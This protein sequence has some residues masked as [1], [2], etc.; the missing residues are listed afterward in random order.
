MSIA[1]EELRKTVDGSFVGIRLNTTKV[2]PVHL[3]N[4][5]FRAILG[6]TA[7]TRLLHRFV[8][9]QEATGEIP[10][11]HDLDSVISDLLD[12]EAIEPGIDPEKIAAFRRQ[13]KQVVSADNGV[14]TGQMQSYSAGAAAFLSKD[15]VGQD[16][17]G[18]VASW[19][20]FIGSPLYKQIEQCLHDQTDIV[21][22]LCQPLLTNETEPF[23]IFANIEDL[24]FTESQL[25]V[26]N[27]NTQWAGLEKAAETLASNLQIHPDKLFRL[28]M[29]VLFSAFVVMRHVSSLESYYDKEKSNSPPPFLLEFGFNGNLKDASKQSYSR[30][31]Q[32]I[33]RF[34][35]FAFGEV[36]KKT[37]T[38]DQLMRCSPP[39]YKEGTKKKVDEQGDNVW[40]VK[41]ESAKTA[42]NKFLLFGEAIFDILAL[43]AEAD[44]IRY[45]RGLGRR[46]GL[47]HPPNGGT[48]PWF[49]PKH[50][51]VE[52]MIY[53]CIEPNESLELS[54]LCERMY[55]RFGILVG[56]G[57][58]DESVLESNGI[59][60]WD[61]DS[62]AENSTAFSSALVDHGFATQLADGVLKVSLE[63]MV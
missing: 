9:H 25:R 58:T 24:K 52:L 46:I 17:G 13:L 55:E 42:K 38:A 41:R 45:F 31:T 56:G 47:L 50:D 33:A 7:S 15:T 44:P 23:E 16:A 59:F 19:L 20:Q 6:K 1:I 22:Q 40:K 14:F 53:S 26:R 36:L 18:F 11:G 48:V 27:K 60:S 32:S 30:C 37:H 57:A 29:T 43:Q 39:R 28:R 2:K 51:L 54:F 63:V 8:F 4:G 3:A 5:L 61:R 12:C 21:S 62:L 10:P 34:Y 35:S 49:R